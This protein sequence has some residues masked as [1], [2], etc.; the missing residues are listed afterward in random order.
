M[1]Q[2][3]VT[4]RCE[5]R[6]CTFPNGVFVLAVALILLFAASVLSISAAVG[7]QFVTV[8]ADK[9]D[10][11]LPR[12]ITLPNATMV[13]VVPQQQS[14]KSTRRGLGLFVWEGVDGEC[15]GENDN[16]DYADASLDDYRDF[17][18][19][20]WDAAAWMAVFSSVAASLLF[21]WLLTFLCV[22]HRKLIRTIFGL[23]L[24]ALLP[25]FQSLTFAVTGSDFCDENDCQLGSSARF[26]VVA[27]GLYVTTGILLLC[28]SKDYPGERRSAV[29]YKRNTKNNSSIEGCTVAVDELHCDGFADAQEVPVDREFVDI[30]LV[31]SNAATPT[32]QTT[33]ETTT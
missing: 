29:S 27:V 16:N 21:V 26:A 4:D 6:P 11:F 5:C 13:F 20:D 32:N 25:I 33:D 31:D 15:I 24:I 14:N 19:S 8:D 17:T 3:R 7:C 30:A 1:F 12:T 2:E 28:F 18:G 10:P 23:I 22:A 9:V